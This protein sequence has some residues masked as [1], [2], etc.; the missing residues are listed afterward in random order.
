MNNVLYILAGFISEYLLKS[1]KD[2][3]DLVKKTIKDFFEKM[4]NLDIR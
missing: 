3:T 4:P 2:K 1:E